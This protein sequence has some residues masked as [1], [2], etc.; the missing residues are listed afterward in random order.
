[1]VAMRIIL[2]FF[3]LFYI[4]CTSLYAKESKDILLIHSYHKG[5]QWSDD[6]SKVI[7]HQFSEKHNIFLSTIYMDTKRIDTDA[8][9]DEFYQYYKKRFDG[10]RFDLIIVADNSALTFAKSH[11]EE[12]FKDIPIVFLGINNFTPSLIEAMPHVTGVVENV[13]IK[14][15]IDLILTLHPKTD[16]ILIINERS[17]TGNAIHEQMEKILPL[18]ADKVAIRYIDSMDMEDI[19]THVQQLSSQSAILWVLLFKDKAGRFFTYKENL[20]EVRKIAHSPIYGLWDFYIGHGIVG[21]FLTSATAQAQAASK[22]VE[23]ILSG[24]DTSH[25]PIVETSPNRY[26]FDHKELKRHRIKLSGLNVDYEVMHKPFSF[27]EE[28]KQLI[29]FLF[30]GF[31]VT[32]M[33]VL[34]LVHNIRIRKS[35]EMAYKNQ[36]EFLRVLVD[37]IPNPIYYTNIKGEYI[38]LNKAFAHLYDVSKEEVLGKT[39]F[40]FFPKDWAQER[41]EHDRELLK[42]KG[43]TTF[44]SMLHIAGKR[45]KLFNFNKAVYTLFDGTTGGIVCVMD[46]ITERLQQRQFLIQQAKLT[47]MGEMIAAIAHQWNEPLV[48][49]SAITQDMEFCFNTGDMDSAKMKLFVKDAM[50]HIQYMSQTLKDFRNFLKPSTKK[51][52]FCAKKAL[53]EILD[54]IGRQIFYAHIT[55]N[56][57]YSKPKGVFPIY[58]YENEF[59]QVLINIINNAK[60]KMIKNAKGQV[61]DIFIEEKEGQTKIVVSDDGGKIPEKIIKFIFDP[62]FTT[63]KE[64]TGLG[65]Y[66]AKII[67]EEKM[68]GSLSA[69]NENNHALFTILAPSVMKLG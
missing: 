9:L 37:T 10:T 66:M 63:N 23:E 7:E 38:G 49:L 13:D 28:Y 56:V 68:G 52:L 54:I 41:Y 2:K 58:G 65:L 3:L 64:G 14:R 20:E 24:K 61:I 4:V 48:E 5:Y 12:L 22:I 21:G 33:V 18:Y 16:T 62:Y 39:T 15:N 31:I 55:L 17:I 26:M 43:T 11:Y 6:I 1:M 42:N 44:E 30:T 40:D 50:I 45:P 32:M 8:Y 29:W 36:L 57:H 53:K 25:I 67:I 51:T 27:Y 46:D 59:K 35:S 34:F 19:T 60:N 69:H 47:E